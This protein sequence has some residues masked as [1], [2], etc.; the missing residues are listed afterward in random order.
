M[1]FPLEIDGFSDG[2]PIEH[3]DFPLQS[4]FNNQYAIPSL[5]LQ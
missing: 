5:L 2:L 1:V 3:S 4:V